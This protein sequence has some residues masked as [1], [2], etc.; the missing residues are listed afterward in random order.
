VIKVPKEPGLFKSYAKQTK[1]SD[2][3]KVYNVILLDDKGEIC[4]YAKDVIVRR[5]SQ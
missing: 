3:E 1:S 4:Y 5:I 2:S